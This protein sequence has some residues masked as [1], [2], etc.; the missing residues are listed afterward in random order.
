MAAAL[1][2]LPGSMYD[3]DR[4]QLHVNQVL[5]RGEPYDDALRG[6]PVVV[7]IGKVFER[8]EDVEGQQLSSAVHD[9]VRRV[10]VVHYHP[11]NPELVVLELVLGPIREKRDHAGTLRCQ[12]RHLK[13]RAELLDDDFAGL[14][15]R[16][17]RHELAGG[18]GEGEHLVCN[19]ALKRCHALGGCRRCRLHVRRRRG[20]ICGGPRA[21]TRSMPRDL[22]PFCGP[23]GVGFPAQGLHERQRCVKAVKL[24]RLPLAI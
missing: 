16:E 14:E 19:A 11:H 9:Q 20:V 8:V 2:S 6:V 23:V 4:R 22:V 15:P 5:P 21:P 17:A 3:G 1:P 10:F 7:V 18:L 13:L 12:R 24:T